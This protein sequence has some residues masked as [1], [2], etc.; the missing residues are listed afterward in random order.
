VGNGQA[1]CLAKKGHFLGGVFISPVFGVTQR[2]GG[3]GTKKG[4]R[5]GE[6]EHAFLLALVVPR[7][8]EIL[9]RSR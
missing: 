4:R 5:N 8:K 7:A 2:W 6:E 9:V 1:V 3:A